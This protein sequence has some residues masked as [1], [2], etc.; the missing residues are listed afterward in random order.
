MRTVGEQAEVGRL[1]GGADLGGWFLRGMD[2]VGGALSVPVAA[3]VQGEHRPGPLGPV[4]EG[5]AQYDPHLLGDVLVGALPEIDLALEHVLADLPGSARLP[6][7]PIPFLGG[8]SLHLL[9]LGFLEL[10]E[11]PVV[12]RFAAH[13]QHGLNPYRE[14]LDNNKE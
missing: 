9:Q 13:R 1:S 4:G 5:L 12:L 8:M 11:D 6:V 3:K 10:A 2:R 7:D 14:Q